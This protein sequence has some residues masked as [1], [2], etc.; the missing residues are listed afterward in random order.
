MRV[1]ANEFVQP[2][3]IIGTA[4]GKTLYVSDIGDKKTYSFKINEDG[5]LTNRLLFTAMGSDGMTID[6]RG[7]IYLTGDGVTVFDTNGTTIIHIPVAEEWTANVTFA[8]K[9]QNILFITAQG[10]QSIPLK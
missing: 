9:D 2:N 3:G 7:T 1:A 6:N 5:T 10:A 4:D 8:G